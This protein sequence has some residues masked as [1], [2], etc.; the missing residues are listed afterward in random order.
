VLA[1]GDRGS[2]A[3]PVEI[4]VPPRGDVIEDDEIV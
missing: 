1:A 3:R 4:Q 2:L